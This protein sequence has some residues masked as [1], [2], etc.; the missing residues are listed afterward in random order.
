MAEFFQSIRDF[1]LQYPILV[2]TIRIF[3]ALLCGAV[4]GLE[5][6]KRSKEAGI[7]THCIIAC[8]AALIMIISKYGFADLSGNSEKSMMGQ[9]PPVLRRRSSAASPSW[10]RESS[11]KTETP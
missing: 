11:S 4:V 2:Y 1:V 10:A 9:T 8:A 5:R 3:A 7:R 6:T